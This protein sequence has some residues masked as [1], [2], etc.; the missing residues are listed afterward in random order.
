MSYELPFLAAHRLHSQSLDARENRL[1]YG[2]CN[3]L[4]GHGHRYRVEATVGGDFDERSGTLFNLT[5]LQS[6][7]AKSLEP[8]QY[9]HL[10]METAEFTD[11]PSTGENI[12]HALWP[13]LNHHLSERLMRLRIWETPNNRFTLR[14]DP[15]GGM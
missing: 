7:L 6:G 9:K 11:N 4:A 8:W 15:K 5:D 13:R 3:N 10:E 2:K 14:K 1:V 12:C